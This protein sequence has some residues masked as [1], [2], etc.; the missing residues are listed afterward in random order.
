MSP[1]IPV[2]HN[3]TLHIYFL[4]YSTITYQSTNTLKDMHFRCV[5]VL[6]VYC[7]EQYIIVHSPLMRWCTDSTSVASPS[8]MGTVLLCPIEEDKK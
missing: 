4:D 2:Y 6:S 8:V 3:Q 1:G 5:I 7:E